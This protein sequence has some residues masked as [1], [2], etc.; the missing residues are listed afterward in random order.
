MKRLI[1]G[2]ILIVCLLVPVSCAKAPT[3]AAPY[4]ATGD[5]A[6][7]GFVLNFKNPKRSGS[8]WWTA[9]LYDPSTQR[10]SVDKEE[11]PIGEPIVFEPSGNTFLIRF[12]ECRDRFFDDYLYGPFLVTASGPGNYT[13]DAG[14]EEINGVK[15]LN[16]PESKNLSKITGEV[17]AADDDMITIK[18]LSAE[19]IFRYY[20]AGQFFIGST[21]KA[22]SDFKSSSILHK[23]ITA[24]LKMKKLPLDGGK[25]GYRYEWEA[26]KVR[27]R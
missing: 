1:I 9:W 6:P 17:R 13:W 22:K 27:V 20:N 23:E 21:I 12:L 2:L 14:A 10:W 11:I 24:K 25:Y 15:T 3:P 4:K 8:N 18:L 5:V 16:L 26:T 19:D 7:A